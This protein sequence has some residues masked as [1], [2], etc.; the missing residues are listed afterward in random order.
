MKE[1]EFNLLDEP[2]IRVI[3]FDCNIDELSLKEVFKNAH[4]YKDLCGE[5]PTQDFAVMRLLLAVLQT[6]FSRYDTQ[7]K[8]ALFEGEEDAFDRWIDLWNGEK[9]PSEVIDDY[10][11]KYRERFYL[12]HPERPFYQITNANAGTTYTAAKLFGN[13]SESGHK[14]RLFP[15]INGEEKMS[16]TYPEAARWLIYIN[17][18]DDSAS[19]TKTGVGWLGQLGALSAVGRN[20]FQTLML[21]LIFLRSDLEPF[22][23]ETPIWEFEKH[24]YAEKAKIAVPDN[25]SQ[26]YTLQSR[27]TF[28]IRENDKVVG[29]NVHGGIF[30]EK[31]NAFIE[32]MTKWK[33]TGNKNFDT[34]VPKEHSS[35]TQFWRDFPS[36]IIDDK[37]EKGQPGVI[38]WI[39]RMSGVFSGKMPMLKLKTYSVHY[40]SSNSFVNDVFSDSLEIHSSLI[41]QLQKSWQTLVKDSVSFCETIANK[42]YTLAKNVNLAEGG[43]FVAKED[44]CSAKVAA[45]NAKAEFYSLIDIPFRR[46]LCSIDPDTD[47]I[48]KKRYEWIKQC[49]DS[50]L[51]LGERIVGAASPS[52][53]FGKDGNSAACALNNFVKYVKTAAKNQ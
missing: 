14:T 6:V 46:W 24:P 52:A 10:L 15:M 27:K 35:S 36:L 19:K 26:L 44:N 5:L 41:S 16:M 49:T 37:S 53:F 17:G 4:K 7:G 50:A 33:N 45:G 11:E 30:F 39:D 9:F 25:L 42:V 47:D 32:P 2:W 13:L 12:F 51:K 38:S 3:D 28:L 31:E 43:D 48:D 21:N 34:F 20:L 18:Y 8:E 23:R 22:E 40:G 29:F 1:K